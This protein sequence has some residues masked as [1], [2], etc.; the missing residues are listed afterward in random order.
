[1]GLLL[2][3]KVPRQMESNDQ[4]LMYWISYEGILGGSTVVDETE[5]QRV[6]SRTTRCP[7]ARAHEAC[8]SR[9]MG[10]LETSDADHDPGPSELLPQSM[11]MFHK[12]TKLDLCHG[13]FVGSSSS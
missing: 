3:A 2:S 8:C 13:G 6:P 12:S 1:M 11:I 4:L 9:R 10:L 7:T 5:C